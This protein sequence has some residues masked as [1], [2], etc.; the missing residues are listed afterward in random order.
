[1]RLPIGKYVI[2]RLP[3]IFGKQAPRV[4]AFDKAIVAGAPT[5]VFPKTHIN[6]KSDSRLTQPI[7]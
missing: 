2:A 6:V 7:H 4:V 3:M 1:M 5:E